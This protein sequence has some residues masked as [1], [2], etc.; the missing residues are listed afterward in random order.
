MFIAEINQNL[1]CCQLNRRPT[2]PCIHYSKLSSTSQFTAGLVLLNGIMYVDNCGSILGH[3]RLGLPA[4]G[5]CS[6]PNTSHSSMGKPSAS[7]MHCLVDDD[8]ITLLEE[9]SRHLTICSVDL[10][11]AFGHGNCMRH[12]RI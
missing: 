10:P 9:P 11:V 4:C 7:V 6:A 1:V 3:A 5:A 8:D 12:E 2:K